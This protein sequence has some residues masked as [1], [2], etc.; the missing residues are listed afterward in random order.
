[1]TT[2][3][4]VPMPSISTLTSCPG[5]IRATPSGV[6]VKITSPG[7]RVVKEEMYATSSGTVKIM[8]LVVPSC[9]TSPSRVVR[10]R[11]S[12]TSSRLW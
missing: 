11:R 9:I 3:V 1:M 2:L 12:A 6:P 8:S 10:I 5:C 4:S 7:S